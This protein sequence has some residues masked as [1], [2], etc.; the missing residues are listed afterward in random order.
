MLGGC[1]SVQV[2]DHGRT[3]IVGFVWLTLPA[4]PDSRPSALAANVIRTR[5][6]GLTLQ[7]GDAGGALT[8]GYSDVMLTSVNNDSTVLLP[9]GGTWGE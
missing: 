1:A 3:H 9:P 7:H 6:V 2:D 5:S 8:L 4:R